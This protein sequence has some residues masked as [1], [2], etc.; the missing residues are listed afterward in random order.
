MANEN[1]ITANRVAATLNIDE[2]KVTQS[3]TYKKAFSEK[4][5]NIAQHAKW[6]RMKQKWRQR[7]SL[8][9]CKKRT[10]DPCTAGT[11]CGAH[12]RFA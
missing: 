12:F 3:V 1:H 4:R 5:H 6:R 8:I 10:F 2:T 11:F 9:R 7:L